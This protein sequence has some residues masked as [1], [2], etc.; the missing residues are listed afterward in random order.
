MIVASACRRA[1]K[2]PSF[3]GSL[4]G[5]SLGGEKR[6][7]FH[8]ALK[9]PS[10]EGLYL[11]PPSALVLGPSGREYCGISLGCLRPHQ[12]PRR[13]MI[14]LVEHRAFDPIVLLSILANCATMAW[15]SPLDPCCTDKAAFLA[16]CED[17]FLVI[18]TFELLVKVVAYGLISPRSSYLRDPWC[19]LD[20]I[21]V[22][23]AWLP[24][25]LPTLG[26]YSGL[27]A[28]R[29]LRPLR[30]LKRVPGMPL[31]VQWIID[32]LPRLV[33]VLTLVAFIFL[34]FGI[35]GMELLKGTLHFRC[36]NGD[37][38][39]GGATREVPV[40]RV[41]FAE[42]GVVCSEDRPEQCTVHMPNASCIHFEHQPAG[43]MLSF[44]T[45]GSVVIALSKAITFDHWAE[46]MYVG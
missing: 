6:P 35:V 42:S 9:P 38:D 18:F 37:E 29:A 28:F 30:A 14:L 23:L 41:G 2:R 5:S 21:I 10:L 39:D 13:W 15:A 24:I 3:Y 16:M 45:F 19:L 22:A 8:G 36:T 11:S 34:T 7:S 40:L 1:M 4:R 33:D 32:V 27:R 44:D 26:N 17:V 12:A 25:F 31:L 46:Q 43:S 20:F